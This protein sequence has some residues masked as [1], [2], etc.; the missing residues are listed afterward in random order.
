MSM[1]TQRKKLVKS[2]KEQAF[3]SEI[4]LLFIDGP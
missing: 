2:G 3:G 1:S 4:Y